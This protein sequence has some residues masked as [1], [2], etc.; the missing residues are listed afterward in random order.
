MK[1]I[2]TVS[3][4]LFSINALAMD[5]ATKT[6]EVIPNAAY[7]ILKNTFGKQLGNRILPREGTVTYYESDGKK[8]STHPIAK[9]RYYKTDGTVKPVAYFFKYFLFD[10]GPAN[11][12]IATFYDKNRYQLASYT[13]QEDEG[14]TLE[15]MAYSCLIKLAENKSE[16]SEKKLFGTYLSEGP[17]ITYQN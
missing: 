9:F 1:K 10:Q 14:P 15:E 5:T 3:L 13:Y 11:L 6:S 4:I 8:I 2:I 17:A 16:A 12:I 7:C